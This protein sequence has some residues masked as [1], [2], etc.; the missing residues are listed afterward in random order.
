MSGPRRIKRDGAFRDWEPPKV[1]FPAIK[2]FE[3]LAMK[4][5]YLSIGVVFA[6]IAAVRISMNMKPRLAITNR[7]FLPKSIEL[8]LFKNTTLRFLDLSG[9]GIGDFGALPILEYL[10]ENNTLTTLILG[11]NDLSNGIG[12][13]VKEM[14]LFNS[15]LTSLG[16]PGNNIRYEGGADIADALRSNTTLAHLDLSNNCIGPDDDTDDDTDDEDEERKHAKAFPQMLKI[17]TTL[18]TLNLGG[19][20]LPSDFGGNVAEAL[21]INSTLRTLNLEGNELGSSLVFFAYMLEENSSLSTLGLGNQ[22]QGGRKFPRI[23]NEFLDSLQNNSTLWSLDI[24]NNNFGSDATVL[25]N[26]EACFEINTTLRSLDL[27]GNSLPQ[28]ILT[29]LNEIM[30]SR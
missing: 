11:F 2:K 6:D 4:L 30:N 23:C 24:S 13:N 7:Y 8:A 29:R 28:D 19:N 14:L 25:N 10:K 17:N 22:Y 27:S 21:E 15:T 26:I 20:N 18:N 3:M 16:L 1:F 12:Q 5:L 9:N